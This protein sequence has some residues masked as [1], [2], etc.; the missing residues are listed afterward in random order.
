MNVS[1]ADL[2]GIVVTSSQLAGVLDVSTK[3][4]AGLTRAGVLEPLKKPNG[5]AVRG[6]YPLVAVVQS[7]GR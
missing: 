6:R 2:D 4:V 3:Y 7:F 1:E 5:T